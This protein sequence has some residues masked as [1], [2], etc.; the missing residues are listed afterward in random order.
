MEFTGNAIRMIF[1]YY[2]SSLSKLCQRSTYLEGYLGGECVA[3][4][5]DGRPVV[6]VPTVKLHTAA[7][8]QQHLINIQGNVMV[9]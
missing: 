8:G 7:P 9:S 3:M 6:A 4:V 5:D 2:I 1:K